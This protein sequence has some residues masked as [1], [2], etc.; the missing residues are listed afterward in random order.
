MPT[1]EI[2]DWITQHGILQSISIL[3]IL[4]G[5]RIVYIWFTKAEPL[6]IM[7]AL[8]NYKTKRLESMLKLSYLPEETLARVRL[9]LV[10]RHHTRLTG[11]TETRLAEA[12]VAI[13]IKRRLPAN[14]FKPWR[15]WLREVDN[16]IE[17]NMASYKRA[18]RLFA[19]FNVPVSCTA[20]MLMTELFAASFGQHVF[21][22]VLLGNIIFWW[23]PWLMLTSVPSPRYTDKML[24]HLV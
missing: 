13:T 8:M 2:L 12:L 14:Y 9:E 7:Q 10:Q 18:W 23:F 1:K 5:F 20:M 24:P 21:A 16:K 22:P 19:W 6:L 17:L 11:V 15:A 3:A 4:M